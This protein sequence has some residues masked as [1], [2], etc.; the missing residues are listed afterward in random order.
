MSSPP[1][2][3]STP[4]DEGAKVVRLA[5]DATRR[6]RR[7]RIL[8]RLRER[9]YID[10]DE[11]DRRSVSLLRDDDPPAGPTSESSDEVHGAARHERARRVPDEE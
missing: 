7:L 3:Q 1:A 6:L 4:E 5:R 8:R 2:D 10:A 11:Y 9:R